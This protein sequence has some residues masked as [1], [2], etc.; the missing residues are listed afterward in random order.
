MFQYI[1]RVR[2]KV[3]I[4]GSNDI[5]VAQS[6]SLVLVVNNDAF[7]DVIEIASEDLGG[8]TVIMG[9]LQPGQCWTVVLT[10]L[11]GVTATCSTDTTLACAI[12]SPA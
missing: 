11:C 9:T 5:Q 7:G 4:W 3:Y 1:L 6:S 2:G 10:G 12:L 8:T